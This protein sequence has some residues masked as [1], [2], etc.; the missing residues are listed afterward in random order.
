VRAASAVPLRGLSDAIDA[1]CPIERGVM[2]LSR[3]LM[4]AVACAAFMPQAWASESI[5][6]GA[7]CNMC[8]AMDKKM[9]GPSYKD[10]AAKYKGDAAAPE[11]LAA[12][13]RNGSKAVWGPAAMPA[14][15]ASRLNDN[16]LKAVVAWI[17]KS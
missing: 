10:I 5:A 15:P 14:T 16:D 11:K 13:V 4:L 12:S 9:L 1:H 8:H 17:L 2:K 7:G 3:T 6:K